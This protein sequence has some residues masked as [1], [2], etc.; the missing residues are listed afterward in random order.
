MATVKDLLRAE[1]LRLGSVAPVAG[2]NAVDLIGVAKAGTVKYVLPE[3]GYVGLCARTPLNVWTGLECNGLAAQSRSNA[4]ESFSTLYI[5]GRKGDSVNITVESTDAVGWLRF[6]KA[7]GGGGVNCPTLSAIFEK[8]GGLCLRLKT[9]SE[10][11][12]KQV[13]DWLSHRHNAPS[14]S[15]LSAHRQP[16]GFVT[17]SRPQTAMSL[18][19]LRAPLALLWSSLAVAAAYSSFHRTPP[20]RGGERRYLVPVARSLTTHFGG[21]GSS[22]GR[23]TSFLLSVASNNHYM[24]VAA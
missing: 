23:S 22:K 17:T 7:I 3:T 16:Q 1:T 19:G 5:Y 10:T 8:G 21:A 24:E 15:R 9:A 6:V 13:A 20:P 2:G 4:G 12:V 14:S 11:S 18:F